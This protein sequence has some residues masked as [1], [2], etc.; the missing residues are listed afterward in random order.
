MVAF[1]GPVSHQESI[2]VS[3]LVFPLQALRSTEIVSRIKMH[4]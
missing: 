4:E 1:V 3:H 2:S